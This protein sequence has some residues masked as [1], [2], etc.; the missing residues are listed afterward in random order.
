MLTFGILQLA[1]RKPH[2]DGPYLAF[3]AVLLDLVV[4]LL[5]GTILTLTIGGIALGVAAIGWALSLVLSTTRTD[6]TARH[7]SRKAHR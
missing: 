1:S 7:L 5:L 6:N 3:V 4:A 2:D